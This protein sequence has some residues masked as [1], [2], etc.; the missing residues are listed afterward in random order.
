VSRNINT[1][2]ELPQ[3]LIEEVTK[4]ETQ[5][6]GISVRFL[7]TDG[8]RTLGSRDNHPFRIWLRERGTALEQSTLGN[9]MQ[10]GGAERAG[11]IFIL[12]ARCLRAQCNLPGD[13]WPFMYDAAAY[14]LNRTP[15]EAIG[16]RTPWIAV[17]EGLGI[18]PI[19]PSIAH[20]RVFGCR[21][22]TLKKHLPK[23]PKTTPHAHIGYLVGY[24]SSN[25]YLIWIP[26]LEKAV[27]IR[28][29]VFNKEKFYSRTE[30]DL[31]AELQLPVKHLVRTIEYDE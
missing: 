18:T 22:Y 4:L 2:S 9:Y 29:V 20:L 19:D 6:P 28:D 3:A 14:L 23:V 11:G 5:F 26:S 10:N 31:A 24:E 30:T 21:A 27:R 17:Q 12:K 8:E 25:V 15:T 16:W 7:K 13:L 1:P